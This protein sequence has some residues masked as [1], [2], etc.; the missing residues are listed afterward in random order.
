MK[1]K[2]VPLIALKRDAMSKNIFLGEKKKTVS[3]DSGCIHGKSEAGIHGFIEQSLFKG[4]NISQEQN[5]TCE[6]FYYSPDCCVISLQ[7]ALPQLA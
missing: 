4:C 1:I 5:L 7:T 6:A 2:E 3:Q